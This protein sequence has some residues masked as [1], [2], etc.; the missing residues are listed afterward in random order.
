MASPLLAP[1]HAA[2]R[3][4][5][6]PQLPPSPTMAD[7]AV[8]LADLARKRRLAAMAGRGSTF[9]TGP[10]GL[11]GPSGEIAR[12][13]L[14]ARMRAGEIEA[15]RPRLPDP[16]LFGGGG[17]YRGGVTVSPAPPRS[18]VWGDLDAL[19]AGDD[20]AGSG[21]GRAGAGAAPGGT[22]GLAAVLRRFLV[23]TRNGGLF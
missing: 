1:G 22:D 13:F 10:R 7:E 5:Q 19:I 15:E 21:A 4:A 8:I 14:L 9:V 3:A 20:A 2:E 18:G 17:A 6:N 16:G 11:E 23:P 12:A